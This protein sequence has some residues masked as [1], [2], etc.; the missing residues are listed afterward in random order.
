MAKTEKSY[1]KKIVVTSP[2]RLS[3]GKKV[4]WTV[5]GN[6]IG[7]L[8]TSDALEVKELTAC[9]KENKYGVQLIDAATFEDLKKNIG[10]N[11]PKPQWSP[12][13]NSDN[14]DLLKPKSA[15]APSVKPPVAVESPAPK[16]NERT[17]QPTT[18]VGVFPPEQPTLV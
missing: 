4:G 16:S 18:A 14:L 8:E 5:V 7:V 9:A 15:A 10:K 1:F 3:T 17:E 12:K 13:V 2:L 11:S 6:N